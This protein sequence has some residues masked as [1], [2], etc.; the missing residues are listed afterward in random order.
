MTREQKIQAGLEALLPSFDSEAPRRLALYYDMLADWNTRMNLTGDT[1]FDVVLSR[2]FLDSVAPLQ[3]GELFPEKAKLADVGSGAGF[4]GLPLAI[5]RQDLQVTLIDSLSKRIGFLDAVSKELGLCNVKAVHARAED[6]GRI[7]GLREQFDISV[8]RAVAPLSMLCEFLLPFVRIGGKA[9]CYKGPAA[10]AEE[11]A[12][13]GASVML[14]GGKVEWIPVN[15]PG[16]PLWQHV[17]AIIEKKEK[18]IEKY[19][20]K[21]GT[22]NRMPLGASSR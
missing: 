6:A 9:I 16:P 1:D 19:P 20:R 3:H 8:A 17:L 2:H 4:P 22:A 21:A 13:N 12:G 11:T 7:D 14:G 15:L 10:K 5:V 18:T